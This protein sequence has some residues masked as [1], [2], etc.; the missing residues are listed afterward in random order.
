MNGGREGEKNECRER[1]GSGG[2]WKG[3]GGKGVLVGGKAMRE[4]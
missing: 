1:E 2:R 4:G 3:G